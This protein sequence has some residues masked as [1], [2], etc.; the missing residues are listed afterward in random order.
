MLSTSIWVAIE[1]AVMEDIPN[2]ARSAGPF[3][4]VFGD[5]FAIQCSSRRYRA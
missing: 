1:M 3:G 4:T 2:V 5:Q